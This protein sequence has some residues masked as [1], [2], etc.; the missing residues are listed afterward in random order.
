MTNSKHKKWR[1][2][3]FLVCKKEWNTLFL[4]LMRT[5]LQNNE[6]NPLYIG[7]CV[8]DC[9][10]ERSTATS[11]L[12]W[13]RGRATSAKLG[14]EFHPLRLICWALY[15]GTGRS[16]IAWSSCHWQIIFLLQPNTNCPIGLVGRNLLWSNTEITIETSCEENDTKLVYYEDKILTMSFFKLHKF[17]CFP[18][19][20]FF[21]NNNLIFYIMF[22]PCILSKALCSINSKKYRYNIKIGPTKYK[23]ICL[24]Y[25]LEL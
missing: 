4:L 3:D 22:N 11:I 10:Q 7:H 8:V 21:F 14:R 5:L 20:N 13:S 2:S 15:Y 9:L 24:L 18:D 16:L 23:S 25:P 19:K 17:S 6:S 1:T 12:L